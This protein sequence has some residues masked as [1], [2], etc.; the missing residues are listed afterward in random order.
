M[1]TNDLISYIEEQL[2]KNIPKE[3]IVSQLLQVGWRPLDIEEGFLAIASVSK[4]PPAPEQ[5]TT[6]SLL[7]KQTIDPYR[8]LPHTSPTEI[9]NPSVDRS[10]KV[11]IPRQLET[12]LD[13]TTPARSSTPVSSF[14]SDTQKSKFQSKVYVYV[15]P[16][17]D[18]HAQETAQTIADELLPTLAPKELMQGSQEKEDISEPQEVQVESLPTT[19]PLGIPADFKDETPHIKSAPK[20]IEHSAPVSDVAPV[21]VPF[22]DATLGQPEKESSNTKRISLKTIILLLVLGIIGG[23]VFAVWAGY[24]T[25]PPFAFSLIKKNP[26]EVILLTGRDLARLDAY[27]V[28]TEITLSSPLLSDIT[29]GL[30][31]G[32]VVLSDERDTISFAIE[33]HIDNRTSSLR[34]HTLTAKSSLLDEPL[35][36]RSIHDGMRSIVSIP[37]MSSVVSSHALPGGLVEISEEEYPAFIGSIVSFIAQPLSGV[38]LG[39]IETRG[40]S[41]TFENE[42]KQ[43]FAE[44]ISSSSFNEKQDTLNNKDVPLRHYNVNIDRPSVRQFLSRVVRASGVSFEG[45][46]QTHINEAIGAVS[47][48]S[49]EVWVDKGDSIIRRYKMSLSVPLSKVIGFSDSGIAGSELRIDLKGTY[50]DFDAPHTIHIPTSTTPLDTYKKTMIDAR[51]KDIVETFSLQAKKLQKIEGSYGIQANTSGSCTSPSSG[52]VFSPLGH[53]SKANESVG[54]I[55]SSMNTL[56]ASISAE[57]VCRS[58]KSAWVIAIPQAINPALISCVD[59]SGLSTNLTVMPTGVRCN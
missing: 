12:A 58:S 34:E 47:V 10:P 31:S 22:V 20:E 21:S 5:K 59:S 2:Q 36:A 33:S 28:Q 51:V 29:D 17:A 53:P 19:Q 40:F 38:V 45:S 54:S 42:T 56:L 37:D 43:A 30:L 57:P 52:S 15:I 55:A 23:G 32:E 49:F 16:T 25:I 4:V 9:Q 1:I 3:S 46:T 27:S 13:K 26:K 44:L 35:S 18:A 39:D 14:A 24:I 8:E 50:Y 41:Q 11:W 7:E 6:S 48:D